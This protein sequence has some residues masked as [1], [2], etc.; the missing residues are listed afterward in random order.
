MSASNGLSSPYEPSDGVDAQS[1]LADNQGHVGFGEVNAEEDAARI[2][3][4]LKAHLLGIEHDAAQ[5]SAGYAW[6][7]IRS[8]RT[9]IVPRYEPCGAVRN[10][11]E[12]DLVGKRQVPSKEVQSYEAC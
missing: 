2:F 1:R 12:R 11:Q 6:S 8:G 10:N 9:S 4:T 3:G 7:F 5:K